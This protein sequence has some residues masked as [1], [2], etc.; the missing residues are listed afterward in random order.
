MQESR[1][2]R[3]LRKADQCLTDMCS[4]ARKVVGFAPIEPRM[5]QIQM[6][7]YGAK[8]LEEAMVMEV[9][10]YLKCEMKI[11]PS[12]IDKP[13]FVRIF[14]PEKED[15]N[16][17]YV[18]FGSEHEVDSVF[19]HTRRIVNK[20]NKITHWIPKQMYGRYRAVEELAYNIRKEEGL[21]TR[22]KIGRSDF[23]LSTRNPN[24]SIW[25]NR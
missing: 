23:L 14:P 17:L 1:V 10:S 13:N 7:S 19:T 8:N 24:T 2:Y 21:K 12:A 9:K 20:E 3:G 11:L 15:W 6:R 25:Y 5:L 18:E 4:A 22:V 16:V